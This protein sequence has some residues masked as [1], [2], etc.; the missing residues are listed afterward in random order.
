MGQRN[1]DSRGSESASGTTPA[2]MLAGKRAEVACHSRRSGWYRRRYN[3]HRRKSFKTGER[4]ALIRQQTTGGPDDPQNGSMVGERSA[5]IMTY[6]DQRATPAQRR[7]TGVDEDEQA[8]NDQDEEDT[9][10]LRLRL[11]C[12]G[13]DAEGILSAERPRRCRALGPPARWANAEALRTFRQKR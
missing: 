13:A 3:H 2:S 5:L 12:N 10:H 8:C 11:H 4:F 7:A 9:R 1:A 6:C